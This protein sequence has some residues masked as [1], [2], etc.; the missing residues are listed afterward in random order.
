MQ[1]P[2]ENV[3]APNLSRAWG[4]LMESLRSADPLWSPEAAR[5]LGQLG[6][7]DA[8]APLVD[9]VRTSWDY[10][11]TAGLYA[12]Q[13]LGD[14]DCAQDL[15]PLVDS[16]NVCEDYY[17]HRAYMVR[18]AAALT[19]RTL[20]AQLAP[21][22]F[23]RELSGE[24][25]DSLNQ[26][27]IFYAPVLMD[28]PP[29]DALFDRL[30]AH[31]LTMIYSRKYTRP[32]HLTR[33]V[34]ALARSGTEQAFHELKILLSWS[35]QY[36]RGAAAEQ[37]GGA[38]FGEKGVPL[39][40]EFFELEEAAFARV[41]AAGAL[42]RLGDSRG[43]DCLREYMRDAENLFV[44][45]TAIDTASGC[46]KL[47]VDELLPY[48][49]DTS[50]WVRASAMDALERQDPSAGLDAAIALMNDPDLQVRLQAAK[51]L[52]ALKGEAS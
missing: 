41:K 2:E 51:S 9:Y 27:C 17:W 10:G 3:A 47:E 8:V 42:S 48:L 7:T 16:P 50:S 29:G 22:F 5:L 12:L 43:P 15:V 45:A 28:L 11:K 14:A 34:V 36:V 30:K 24:A 1:Y 32:S 46:L 31:T 37:L 18:A 20:D 4:L 13:Q 19:V 33:S 39:L 6:R 44:K 35:S 23:E 49:K 25:S 38:S 21:Q 40:S 52:L 26:F